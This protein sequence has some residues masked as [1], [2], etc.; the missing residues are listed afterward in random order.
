MRGEQ[1][2]AGSRRR[3]GARRPPACRPG[4][5]AA[6]DDA[7]R[8]LSGI[9]PRA[10]AARAR[11]GRGGIVM[12]LHGIRLANFRSFGGRTDIRFGP[13]TSIVGPSGAGKS[14][15]LL[16]LE[17]I[18]ALIL[19]RPYEPRPGD[20]FD[21]RR[22]SEMQLGATLEMSDQEQ[23]S[24]LARTAYSP[25]DGG[26]HPA[27]RMPLRFVRY[28]ATFRGAAKQR[29]ELSLS[30]S[31]AV[32]HPFARATLERSG[33]LVELAGLDGVD[34]RGA[35][36]AAPRPYEI[37]DTVSAEALAGM[38]NPS[39]FPSMRRLWSGLRI[40][41]PD[42]GIPDRVPALKS[43]AIGADGQN[44]PNELDYLQRPGQIAFDE[45]METVTGGDPLGIRPQAA[46]SDTVLSVR[47]K[48]LSRRALHADLG[49]GQ[50]QTLIL[51]WQLFRGRDRILAIKDPE[52]YLHAGRQKR[53][54]G[55]ILDK[56]RR[57]GTQFVI[58]TRSPAFLGGDGR[59]RTVLVSK[60]R[61]I[62]SA[63]EVGPESAPAVRDA[64]GITHADALYPDDV[65]LVEGR[66]EA[67]SF[68]AFLRRMAPEQARR[69][70]IHNLEGG[71]QIK[72]TVEL[73]KYLE[74][75]EGRRTFTI[76]DW[77]KNA[78][79][80]V[81]R[82]KERGLLVDNVRFLAKSFEDA[83][84]DKTIAHALKIMAGK[85][86]LRV[87]PTAAD[88]SRLRDTEKDVVTALERWWKSKTGHGL[89]K[90][91]LADLLASLVDGRPPEDIE[92]ALKSAVAHFKSAA[93]GDMGTSRHGWTEG[94]R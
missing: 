71:D 77:N 45:Y 14:N 67:A 61:G 66:S 84:E 60:D 93:E 46:G 10:R 11:G 30:T 56:G 6:R 63:T 73:I 36:P 31:G 26:H 8:P 82:M 78:G 28:A 41:V 9:R 49:S 57:G 7:L 12:R 42:R 16:A 48:G 91:A 2:R 40:A 83:F 4:V 33:Y 86:G 53:V 94:G 75:T 43:S 37:R 50:R 85:F 62:S 76:L 39:L 72:N 88:I 15:I 29:E 92:R 17:K 51:G 1:G 19:G 13:I 5:A 89:D 32:L 35:E 24:L 68:G 59:E 3:C 25:P 55:L 44:L 90:V 38:V 65:L 18:A 58:E 52:L 20:Y 21:N 34:F 80:H 87:A 70:G 81:R 23:A 54:L 69:T 22:D 64:L 74:N 79:S 47:E 27:S